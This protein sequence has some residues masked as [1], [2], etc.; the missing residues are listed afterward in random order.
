MLRFC[1]LFILMLMPCL[2]AAQTVQGTA[3]VVDGDT[4]AIGQERIRLFAIDA[5]EIGQ[6]CDTPAGSWAC[7]RWSR[8]VMAGLVGGRSVTCQGIE[9]DRYD[10]LVAR[11]E[12]GGQDLGAAM[13]LQGAALAYTRYGFDYEEHEKS[14]AIA[15]AGIWRGT[16]EEPETL[17][18]AS[19]QSAG[20]GS[21]AGA[22]SGG[23]CNIKGNISGSGRIYHMPGQEYYDRTV[24]DTRQGE[25]WFCSPAEAEAAG[26]RRARR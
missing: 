24:I 8:D 23:G 25:R 4:L 11:C 17:R 12:A 6:Q 14:A 7:G 3:R 16:F 9:R 15:G 20:A 1:S 2:A 10:R 18:A 19:R 21:A 26:W 5:P 13:V 22:G